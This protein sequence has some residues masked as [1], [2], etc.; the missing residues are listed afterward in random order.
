M[1][2]QVREALLEEHEEAGRVTADSYR[3]FVPLEGDPDWEEYLGMI[4]D[5]PGRAERTVILVA[6]DGDRIA[7][8][9]TLELEGR[10][11]EDDRP[12]EPEEAH[13]RMLGVLPELRGRGAGRAL[14][15]E[16]ERRARAAG[17]TLMT[18]HTTQ[19]MTAAQRMYESLGYTRGEDQVFPDGFVLLSYSKRL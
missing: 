3:E 6:L 1:E 10:V 11:E 4:A 9:A 8:S 5:I 13:I 19:K 17:K 16:C 14:M 18:L 12:L 2:L 15:A 7:G